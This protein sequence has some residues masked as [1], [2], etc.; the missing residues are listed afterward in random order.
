MAELQVRFYCASSDSDA[1]VAALRAVTTS[2][3]H[4]RAEQVFGRDVGDARTAEQVRGSLGRVAIELTAA[5][6]ALT[7]LV[8]AVAGARRA[9]P[10]RWETS[11][12]TGRG[13]I[14]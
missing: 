1:V 7:T 9:R 6:D 14:E 10:V 4:V 11:P 8:D 13:R 12:I 5:D 3:V 2:P